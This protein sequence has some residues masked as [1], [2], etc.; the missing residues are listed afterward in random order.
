MVFMLYKVVETST[1]TDEE[2]EAAEPVD[3]AGLFIRKHSV[4]SHGI[5]PAAE[6]GFFVFYKERIKI[7]FHHGDPEAREIY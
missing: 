3:L 2:I 6:N 7:I 5:I 1:V 4:R